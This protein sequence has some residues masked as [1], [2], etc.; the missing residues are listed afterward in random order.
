MAAVEQKIKTKPH[1]TKVEQSFVC[2]FCHKS[3]TSETRYLSHRC[4]AMKKTEEAQ[5]PIGQAALG[6]YQRWMRVMKKHP[7]ASSAFASSKYFRT[8]IN[9]AQ[10]VADVN[11]PLPDKFIWLMNE[12]KY[13]P[14]MWTHDDAY[15]QYLEFLDRKAEA[16]D[17]AMLSVKTLIK[18]SDKHD[19][20]IAN[21]FDHIRPAELIHLIRT[22]QLSPWLLLHSTKFKIFFRDNM[23]DEQK[24]IL[25][26]LVNPEY[27]SDQFERRDKDVETIKVFIEELGI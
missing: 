6:Y 4:P 17:Q 9:F 18:I 19:D 20:D 16:T 24:I 21:V 1:R 3:L 14:M 10:F 15:T 8:F 25:E 26:A 7:P 27:W 13:P 11:L 5:S 23:S 2:K 12:K 22:R